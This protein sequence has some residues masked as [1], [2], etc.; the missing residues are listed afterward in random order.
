MGKVISLIRC[1]DFRLVSNLHRVVETTWVVEKV[2]RIIVINIIGAVNIQ[3]YQ[4]HCIIL[5]GVRKV[6][7][8]VSFNKK[9]KTRCLDTPLIVCEKFNEWNSHLRCFA[10]TKSNHLYEMV[11]RDENWINYGRQ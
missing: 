1:H 8:L 11:T 7:F 4:S 5:Y 6:T 3:C 2:F 10:E 9:K